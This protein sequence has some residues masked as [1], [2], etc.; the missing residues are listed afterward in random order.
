[1]CASTS[2]R[3]TVK[4]GSQ[5]LLFLQESC[6]TLSLILGKRAPAK[7]WREQN[8]L[9][10][11]TLFAELAYTA[12]DLTAVRTALTRGE[13]SVTFADRTVTY[14]SVDELKMVEQ[15]ILRELA[16]TS[17]RAKQTRVYANKGF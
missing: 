12:A 16:S 1:M 7:L 2:R 5:V 11:G 6:R 9:K 15:D 14:R 13:R 4:V 3:Y 17:S 10:L 8:R